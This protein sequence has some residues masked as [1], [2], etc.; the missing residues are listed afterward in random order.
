MEMVIFEQKMKFFMNFM[1][2]NRYF[3][4]LLDDFRGVCVFFRI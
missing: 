4:K 3:L 2:K 1:N